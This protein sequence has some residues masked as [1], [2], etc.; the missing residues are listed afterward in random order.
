MKQ[1]CGKSKLN[2]ILLLQQKAVRIC[3]GS[4]YMTQTDSLFYLLKALKVHDIN[5][6]LLI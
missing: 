6:N 4:S 1:N 5:I 3:T 2:H